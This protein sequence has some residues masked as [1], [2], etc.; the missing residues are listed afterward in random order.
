MYTV[1]QSRVIYLIAPGRSIQ[2]VLRPWARKE[3][4]DTKTQ[5]TLGSNGRQESAASWRLMM[6]NDGE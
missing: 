2:H 6:G 3:V 1:T 4:V 5:T